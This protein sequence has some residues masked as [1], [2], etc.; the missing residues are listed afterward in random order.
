MVYK[1]ES[2][3]VI[4]YAAKIRSNLRD[5]SRGQRESRIK[6]VDV[7]SAIRG[8]VCPRIARSKGTALCPS[9]YSLKFA[10]PRRGS[11]IEQARAEIK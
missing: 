3:E 8:S 11:D 4:Y 5:E 2:N 6:N 9:S 7:C 1:S 10:Q